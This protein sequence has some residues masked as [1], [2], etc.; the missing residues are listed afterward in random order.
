MRSIE[1]GRKASRN[2]G[3]E[4]PSS[5]RINLSF[6]CSTTKRIK[7]FRHNLLRGQLRKHGITFEGNRVTPSTGLKI[8][9]SFAYIADH[10]TYMRR[11]GGILIKYWRNG[12]KSPEG[13][14]IVS[15]QDSHSVSQIFSNH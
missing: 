2:I 4:Y 7:C 12:Y 5:A 6:Y 14:R 10:N 11:S 15:G 9:A 3:S 1:S 8:K 13:Y